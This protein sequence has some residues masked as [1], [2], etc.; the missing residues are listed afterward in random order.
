MED[1][2]SPSI[3]IVT[4]QDVKHVYFHS[5]I[6]KESIFNLIINLTS[7][8]FEFRSQ[9]NMPGFANGLEPDYAE[10][11]ET[12]P[13]KV[14]LHL[15]CPGG[16]VSHAFMAADTIASLDIP[17]DCIVEGT[18]ASA[19]IILLLACR[20]RAMMPHASICFHDTIHGVDQIECTEIAQF[21][22][23]AK[24]VND[25]VR[26]FY[27]EHT[28]VDKK[29]LGKWFKQMKVFTPEEAKIYNFVNSD[30]KCLL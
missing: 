27:T 24:K 9:H 12:V 8:S 13:S 23:D 16:L 22:R 14:I 17:V 5:A 25:S 6:T 29:L 4:D 26:N 21:L 2:S 18:V 10:D 7:I 11:A 20:K 1:E 28:G 3:Y 30:V 15:S 19:G